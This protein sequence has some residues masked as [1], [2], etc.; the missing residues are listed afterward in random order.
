[1]QAPALAVPKSDGEHTVEAFHCRLNPPRVECSQQHLGVR[2]SAEGWGFA[3][4]LELDAQRL[5]VIDLAVQHND[6]AARCGH[7]RL[8]AG[9]RN[10]DDGK[11][12]KAEGNA[13][14]GINPFAGIVR[15]A[16]RNRF[17]HGA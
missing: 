5:E 7:H 6:I 17:A 13:A 12:S 1:M 3:R 15:T 14:R 2:V 10:I 8:V 4:F 11:P 9:G 16:M